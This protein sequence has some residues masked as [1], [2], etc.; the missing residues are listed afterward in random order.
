[1]CLLNL[2][3]KMSNSTI[4]IPKE[5]YEKLKSKAELFEHYVETEVL[6]REELK[7]I[8]EALKGPFLTKTEF[9]KKHPELS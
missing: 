3:D 4:T 8:K 6:N 2:G 7:Q 5:E 9:L 1:M